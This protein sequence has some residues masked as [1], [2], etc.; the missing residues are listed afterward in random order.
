[1]AEALRLAIPTGT[2][3]IQF[4]ELLPPV[5]DKVEKSKVAEVPLEYV[6]RIRSGGFVS[7]SITPIVISWFDQIGILTGFC[8]IE[9]K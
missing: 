2:Y 8:G 3:H 9:V 5:I 6:T 1:M 7:P 4:C